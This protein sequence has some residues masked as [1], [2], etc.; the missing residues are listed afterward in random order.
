[1]KKQFLFIYIL[2]FSLFFVSSCTQKTI[3]TY[4]YSPGTAFDD[5]ASQEDSE[6]KISLLRADPRFVNWLEKKSLHRHAPEL[7]RIVTGTSLAWRAPSS[8]PEKT[9]I[10]S[11]SPAWFYANPW[12][13]QKDDNLSYFGEFLSSKAPQLLKNIGIN[14]LYFSPTVSYSLDTQLN[15]NYQKKDFQAISKTNTQSDAYARE[16]TNEHIS[17]HTSEDT[18][19]EASEQKRIHN[20]AQSNEHAVI[21]YELDKTVGTMREYQLL[22]QIPM[23]MGGNILEPAIGVG[24]DFLLALRAVREYAGLFIMTELPKEFWTQ[25]PI[26]EDQ[27]KLENS[28]F[29]PHILDKNQKQI[30]IQQG[31]IPAFFARDFLPDA[32]EHGFAL[33][34]PIRGIDSL[35]RRWIYRYAQNPYRPLLNM[36]DPNL[37]AHKL[38]TA[39]II[40]QIGILHQPLIGIS[41]ADLWGQESFYVS[42]EE[43]TTIGLT[44]KNSTTEKPTAIQSTAEKSTTTQSITENFT[45]KESISAKFASVKFAE[46]ALFALK[47][48]NKSIHNYGS[49]SLIRDAFPMEYIPLLLK[50]NSDFVADTIFM[51]ALEKSFLAGNATPLKEAVQNAI[52]LEIPFSSLWHGSADTYQKSFLEKTFTMPTSMSLASYVAKISEDEAQLIQKNMNLPRALQENTQLTEKYKNAKKIQLS[53]I[54]LSALLPGINFISGHDI[55]GTIPYNVLNQENTN[56]QTHVNLPK[57]PLVQNKKQS[58]APTA[59]MLN[60]SLDSQLTDKNSLVSKLKSVYEYRQENRLGEAKIIALLESKEEIF[61]IL[62]QSPTNKYYIILINTSDKNSRSKITIPF[63]KQ[64]F[65][66]GKNSTSSQRIYPSNNNF[67]LYLKA[68]EVKCFELK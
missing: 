48:W 35:E 64:N 5:K 6:K 2:C 25:F 61:G 22:E 28:P 12:Q 16:H 24:P 3:S 13:M 47:I 8:T 33:T 39:S 32:N 54:S 38:F 7:I 56:E 29:L 57:Y 65:T 31:I 41:V 30:L 45:V 53:Y 18:N 62:M 36:T 14:A 63:A 23:I 27:E 44:E 40:Q 9:N 11:T 37:N 19:E 49:W 50:E 4:K 58:I 21:S 34:N 42:N 17:E 46:P 1:M 15:L 43:D 26:S 20:N 67:S 66:Y 10:L 68:W 55:R 60:T 59:I 51:P 52:R